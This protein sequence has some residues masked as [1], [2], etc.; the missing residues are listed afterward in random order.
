[1]TAKTA[2]VYIGTGNGTTVE[3]KDSQSPGGGDNLFICSVVA[4]DANTGEYMWHYQIN[5]GESWDYNAAMDIELAQLKI[6]GKLRDV[7]LTAPKNGFFYVI[8]RTD[9]K[10]DLRR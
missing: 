10:T 2:E 1:M 4:I 7:V 5:P 6:D 8:D 9:R 3:P